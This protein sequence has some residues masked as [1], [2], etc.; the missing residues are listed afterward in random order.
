MLEQGMVA[1]NDFLAARVALANAAQAA[2]RASNG[3]D[4][5][6]AAYNRQ[7]GR[8]LAAEVVLAE[9]DLPPAS[10]NLDA[11]TRTAIQLRPELAALSAQANALRSEAKQLKPKTCRTSRAEACMATC[12]IKASNRTT[13]GWPTAG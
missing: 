7:V 2:R 9:I 11:L 8:S 12:R 5:S 10:E 4:T 13:I 3:L 1:K 6:R